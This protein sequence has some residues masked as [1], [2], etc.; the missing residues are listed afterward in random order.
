[1]IKVYID[2]GMGHGYRGFVC[3]VDEKPMFVCEEDNSNLG[4]KPYEFK[5][6]EDALTLLKETC[7]ELKYCQFIGD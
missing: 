3:N 5:S 6:K 1:M 4:F 2:Y 7:E